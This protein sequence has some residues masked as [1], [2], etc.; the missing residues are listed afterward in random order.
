M[1]ILHNWRRLQR[2]HTC[3]QMYVVVLGKGCSLVHILGK[4]NNTTFNLVHC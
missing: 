2:S 4:V 3:V 1:T